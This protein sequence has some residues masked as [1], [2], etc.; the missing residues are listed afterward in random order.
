VPKPTQPLA[1][2]PASPR[3]SRRPWAIAVISS[4]VALIVFG[5]FAWLI[6]RNSDSA[7]TSQVE[8]E[9]PSA[10]YSLQRLE[11]VPFGYPELYLPMI[12]TAENQLVNEI[13]ALRKAPEPVLIQDHV[14]LLK[15]IHDK[16]ELLKFIQNQKEDIKGRPPS[17]EVRSLQSVHSEPQNNG[18]PWVFL[19]VIVLGSAIGA[20]SW[21]LAVRRHIRPQP[22]RHTFGALPTEVPQPFEAQVFI[23]YSSQDR[24]GVEKLVQQIEKMGCAIWIDRQNIGSQRYAGPIV[25]AIKNSRL[26]ALM[27]SQNAFAS[28][29]VIR[30]VYVAGKYKKPF[31]A[32]QL[33][34]MDIPAELVYFLSGFPL[35]PVSGMNLEQLRMEIARLLTN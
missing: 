21:F 35:I 16:E 14:A 27:C 4:L 11:N 23:S 30:E 34:T 7:Q 1:R 17:L 28:D 18:T 29:H 3:P 19:T 24:K 22:N 20:G 8:R 31:I 2:A 10:S 6:S 9:K 15:L 33:D 26:V 12:E 25:Q 13:G 32:F 5:T